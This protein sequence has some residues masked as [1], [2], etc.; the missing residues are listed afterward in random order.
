MWQTFKFEWHEIAQH[1]HAGVMGALFLACIL[2]CY[3][4]FVDPASHVFLTVLPAMI[5]FACLLVS[6]WMSEYSFES[7]ARSGTL[8]Y[9]LSQTRSIPAWIL[10]R[11]TLIWLVLLCPIVILGVLA[12][13]LQG[14]PQ[15]TLLQLGLSLLLGTY[16]L[17]LITM[18]PAA[19]LVNLK[20][21]RLLLPVLILPLAAPMIIFAMVMATTTHVPQMVAAACWLAAGVL[22]AMM[23]LPW[24]ISQALKIGLEICSNA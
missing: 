14:L 16:C 2:L 9:V 22:I 10:L 13:A 23:F 3:P 21:N 12:G 17:T 24:V 20:F 5:W 8:I 18:V 6:L 15:Q 19:L 7:D 4:F 11:A 1:R